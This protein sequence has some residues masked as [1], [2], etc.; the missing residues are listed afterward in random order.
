MNNF[1][2]KI[3]NAAA[4]EKFTL[5][6]D[7]GSQFI[8]VVKL[9]NDK[10]GFTLQAADAYNALLDPLELLKKIRQD[11]ALDYANI[12][13]S[14]STTV[15]RYINF[16]RMNL[17]EL[18]QA[19]KFE[20]QKHIPF[21]LEEV[22]LDAAVLINDLPDNKMLVLL[23][24]IKKEAVNQ[25]IK[26]IEG[27]GLK[28]NLV[29]IDSVAMVNAF[30]FNYPKFE[31][32]ETK[33][34]GLLNIGA[35]LTNINIIDNHIPRLSRDIHIGGKNITDKLM[36]IFNL[37]FKAAE[38]LKL[39][40]GSITEDENKI[41]ASVESVLANLA[42]EIRTSF[43]YYESQNTSSVSRIYLCGG[44]AKF[45]G[46]KEMLSALLG[47]EIEYWDPFKLIA[48]ADNPVSKPLTLSSEFAVALGLALHKDD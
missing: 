25:R 45:A 27:A 40:S 3:K 18:R 39:N 24:A 17:N 14:G 4:K 23:A 19:M 48:R 38:A 22:Y 44:G 5:G 47:I 10:S 15:L 20:A 46:L 42:A 1:F 2:R 21:T 37:D 41:R 35:G 30:N 12:S 32:A 7:I 13:F 29:D 36:D 11:Y 33:A 8:K 31:D 9:K 34:V 28:V 26:S 16:P 43:D 6:I